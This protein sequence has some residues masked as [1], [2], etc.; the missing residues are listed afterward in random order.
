MKNLKFQYLDHTGDAQFRAFG[1]SLEQAFQNAAQA[2]A[3]LMWDPDQIKGRIK[4]RIQISG[5][6]REQLLVN[7]LE[8]LVFLFESQEFLLHSVMDLSIKQVKKGFHLEA[9]FLGDR[10]SEE[11]DIYGS[12]KAVTY[13][14]MKIKSNDHYMVQVV[15]DI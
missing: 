7:F 14:D 2:T 9:L 3:N 12:V 10:L 15:L 6:D 5:K 1:D 8:E 11:H 4:K 13:N